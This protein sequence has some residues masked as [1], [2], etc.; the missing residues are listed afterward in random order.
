MSI[1]K[2]FSRTFLGIVLIL[3]VSFPA[4]ISFV[5][6]WWWFSEVGFSEIFTKTLITKF[7]VGG[8][9]GL[10]AAAFLVSNFLIAIRSK[11]PWMTTLPAAWLGQPMTL[12]SGLAKKAGVIFG[13]LAAFLMDLVAVR[14]LAGGPEGNF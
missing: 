4:I 14:Q 12:N 7:L 6:D 2:F 13:V 9:A 8:I 3:A 10:F 11:A 5:T 1:V